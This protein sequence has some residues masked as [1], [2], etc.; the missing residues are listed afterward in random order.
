ME[1]RKE[2]EERSAVLHVQGEVLEHGAVRHALETEALKSAV[3]ELTHDH[4]WSP[5]KALEA[6][7]QKEDWYRWANKEDAPFKVV[8]PVK[9]EKWPAAPLHV[10]KSQL[11]QLIA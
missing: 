11:R 2:F 4:T 5:L 1:K 9:V 8:P 3:H 7:V 10:L 6:Q